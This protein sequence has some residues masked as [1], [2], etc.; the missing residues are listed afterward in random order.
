M[1]DDHGDILHGILVS[2]ATGLR[3]VARDNIE[4]MTTTQIRCS[5]T[6]EQIK[7]LP[8]PP[9]AVQSRTRPWFTRPRGKAR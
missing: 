9:P 5:L 7:E 4:R 8:P 1:L 2:T 6:D 3:F